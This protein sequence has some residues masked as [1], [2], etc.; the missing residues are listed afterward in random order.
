MTHRTMRDFLSA[1]EKR[2]L[3]RRIEKP[4]DRMW[5]PAAMVKWMYQA[6]PEEKR[7]GMLCA[8]VT[9]SEMPVA[10]AALG[11]NTA[12]Y[13]AALGVEPDGINDALVRACLNPVAPAVV[14]KAACQEVV[15]TGKDARLS[16]LPILVWTPG[17]DKGPYITTVTVTR[18][19]DTG[20]QNMGVYRTMVRDETSV[21]SNLQPGRH[22]YM[23]TLTWTG[24]GKNAPIAW[25][26][27]APP[28]V[29]LASVGR[30][31][32][33]AEEIAFAGGMMGAPVPMVKCRTV[34]LHVPADAEIIIEGEVHP[35][36]T[37][38]E[39]PFG[40]FAGYMGPVDPR[41]VA[42]ITA[43]TYRKNPIYY[44][45]T[46]Q[47]PPSESTTIQSLTNAGVLLKALRHDLGEV[48]VSDVFIDLTF[49]G[50]L[51][52]AIVAMKPGY[53][54]HSKK[55]GRLLAA[56]SSVKR[57]TV[58]DDDVDIRDHTHVD[59]AMNSRFNPA[60]DTILIDDIYYRTKAGDVCIDPSVA[61]RTSQSTM[62]SK[63]ICDA[64]LKSDAGTFSL[65]SKE[66]M[67]KALDSWKQA[68]L[69]EFEIPKRAKLR[70]EGS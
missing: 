48:T 40:E 37:E 10:T 21:V 49:G 60:R 39:G 28:A 19:F 29:H 6:L 31:A 46:S 70:I 38:I 12:T 41:P 63:I 47:M 36:E 1:L 25:V 61:S 24:K 67:M 65:P 3:L 66:I 68:G 54:A 8:N 35:G 45:L 9:G 14:Q 52:H 55:V 34:D 56:M 51:A 59:W 22:G 7:F 20:K 4:V 18:D 43:I 53:P 15:L 57:V 17:K 58:V 13:A 26:I 50:V 2:G 62:G 5:E 64:T 33:G 23:N 11:A 42:H 44:G 30:L 32:Y 27:G 16:C 69:P